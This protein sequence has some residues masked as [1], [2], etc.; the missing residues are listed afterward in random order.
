[1]L[2]KHQAEWL[3]EL[4]TLVIDPKDELRA[5]WIFRRGWLHTL[6]LSNYGVEDMR[7]VARSPALAM[8]QCL[9][10]HDERYEEP[11]EYAPGPDVGGA[12][13]P[14]LLPLQRSA[15][16]G[17]VRHFVLGRAAQP[18]RRARSRRRGHQLPHRGRGGGGAGEEDAEAGGSCTC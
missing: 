8:L 13:Y 18:R 11:D 17:N 14:Q 12:A 16:L 10:L 3:G 9:W 5:V 6:E 1:M 2:K 7:I 4:G 15:H